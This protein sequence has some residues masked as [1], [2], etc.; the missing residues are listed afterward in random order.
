M[1]GGEETPIIF[2][3]GDR[4]ALGPV[5]QEHSETYRR[6]MND[7]AVTRTLNHPRQ[8]SRREIDSAFESLET[9]ASIEAFTIYERIGL[10]PVGEA[11]L[12]HVDYRNRTA[13]FQIVIGE[14]DARGK[15]Y[16]IETTR[17]VLDYGFTVLGLRNIMLKVYEYN[18]AGLHAYRKAGFREFGRRR[19]AIEMNGKPWD[20]IYMECLRDEF[21]SPVLGTI[22]APDKPR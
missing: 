1:N 14:A 7:P 22:F 20:V 21:Q 3:T 8:F 18:L 6:W 12:T 5:Y 15:G 19:Q 11:A 9:D 17:L 13:E 4:V 10:R 16:G 2:V